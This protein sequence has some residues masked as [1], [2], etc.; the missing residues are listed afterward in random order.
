MTGDLYTASEW[1]PLLF[2]GERPTER[3]IAAAP[4]LTDWSLELDENSETMKLSG[5]VFCHPKY[6]NGKE[7]TLVHLYWMNPQLEYARVHSGWCRLASP[8]EIMT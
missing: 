4:L 2:K 3:A 1:M 6:E 8:S 5:R 7:I